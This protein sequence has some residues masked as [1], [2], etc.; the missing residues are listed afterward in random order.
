MN[1][2]NLIVLYISG[3]IVLK[4]ID[5][6]SYAR[7]STSVNERN[8]TVVKNLLK[9]DRRMTISQISARLGIGTRQVHSI[10][11]DYLGVSNVSSRWV[12]RLLGPEQ[13][14]NRSNTCNSLQDLLAH[15]DDEF[16]QGIMTT[17]ET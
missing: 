2:Q 6:P 11:Y 5:D 15:Y 17:D 12:P 10:L 1:L 3:P 16:W 4:V 14:L 7:P 13:K 8:V 9:E